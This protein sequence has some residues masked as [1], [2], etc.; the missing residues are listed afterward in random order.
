MDDTQEPFTVSFKIDQ[1]VSG[2]DYSIDLG[3]PLREEFVFDEATGWVRLVRQNRWTSL[4]GNMKLRG[5]SK[6]ITI[7]TTA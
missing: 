1:F 6:H 5:D 2:Y 7:T 3:P 4:Y